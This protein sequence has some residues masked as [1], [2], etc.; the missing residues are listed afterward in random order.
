MNRLQKIALYNLTVVIV[1]LGFTAGAVAMMVLWVRFP[2]ACAGFGFLGICAFTMLAPLFF[3]REKSKVEYDE[4]DILITKNAEL[5]A[6]NC[7]NAFFV[8]VSITALFIFGLKGT[9]SV[10]TLPIMV[11]GAYAISV[12]ARSAAVLAQYG[13]RDKDGEG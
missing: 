3:R 9:V 10:L 11:A 8:L 7:S 13:R 4:R 6:S 2:M 5:I 1:S 12:L